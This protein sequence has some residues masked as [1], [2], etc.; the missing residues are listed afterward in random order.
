MQENNN[1]SFFSRLRSL[2]EKKRKNPPQSAPSDTFVSENTA[3]RPDPSEFPSGPFSL[4][5]DPASDLP[6]DPVSEDLAKFSRTFLPK[7]TPKASSFGFAPPVKPKNL[8]E[9][10]SFVSD[11]LQQNLSENN[12]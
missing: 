1:T 2:F 3:P 6:P 7:I 5:H 8:S 11:M 4:H 10:G 12:K 9:A